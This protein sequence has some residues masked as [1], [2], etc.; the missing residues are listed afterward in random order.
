MRMLLIILLTVVLTGCTLLN[1]PAAKRQPAPVPVAEPVA[2]PPAPKGPPNDIL[3]G[4][5]ADRTV[6][7]APLEAS[8]AAGSSTRR[9]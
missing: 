6:D 3:P 1:R 4:T 2:P 9:P 8:G 5:P 7:R